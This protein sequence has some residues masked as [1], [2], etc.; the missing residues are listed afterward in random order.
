MEAMG[1]GIDVILQPAL[2]DGR[3][4][5]RPDVLRKVAR[6]SRLDDWSYEGADTKLARETRGATI[7]QLATYSDMLRATQQTCLT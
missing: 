3:W 7:L 1:S 5:G 2:R 4:F 6:P